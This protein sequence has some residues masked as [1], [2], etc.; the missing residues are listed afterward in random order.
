MET[1]NCIKTRRSIRKFSDKEVPVDII[2]KIIE[3]AK[4]A[5]SSH[6]SQPWQ[7]FIIK[8]QELKAKLAELDHEDN[9]PIIINAPALILICIDLEKSPV[10]FVEDGV[11]ATQNILLASYDLG[12]GSVY[13]SGYKPEDDKKEKGIRK[14]L[15]LKNNLKPIA[16]L[17]LG[18]PAESEKL[19]PKTIRDNK[20]LIGYR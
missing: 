20:D 17:P 9:R 19:E 2:E 14:T 3:A 10:R 13:L 5:P 7:F 11:L 15:D 12:L 16:L 4:Y 8:S 6:D 1:L 18:Y